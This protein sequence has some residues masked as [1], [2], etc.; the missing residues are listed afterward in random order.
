M[1]TDWS[2]GAPSFKTAWFV[3]M[4]SG[5]ARRARDPE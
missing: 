2:E 4:D 5:L 3:I 1:P